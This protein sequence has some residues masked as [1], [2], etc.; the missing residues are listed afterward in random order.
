M[1][2]PVEGTFRIVHQIGEFVLQGAAIVRVN[3]TLLYAPISGTLRSLTRDGVPVAIKTKVIEVDPRLETP[4]IS[5]VAERPGKI[6]LGV[7]RAIQEHPLSTHR[8]S[9]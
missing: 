8:P 2:A 3:D 6:A 9:P 1:Y 7:L 5:G 4:Q